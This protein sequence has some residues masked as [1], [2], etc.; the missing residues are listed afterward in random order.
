MVLIKGLIVPP[1][2]NCPF[3]FPKMGTFR[4]F[5]QTMLLDNSTEVTEDIENT[6]SKWLENTSPFGD[7]KIIKRIKGIEGIS[8]RLNRTDDIVCNETFLIGKRGKYKMHVYQGETV[9]LEIF[10]EYP[11]RTPLNY[12]VSDLTKL[13][14]S[15]FVMLLSLTIIYNNNPYKYSFLK[16][17]LT[18]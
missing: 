12:W 11:K 17:I 3:Y 4:G 9:N 8:F 10:V 18:M 14:I 5:N 2:T 7:A 6:L 1:H 13:L 15:F 16:N